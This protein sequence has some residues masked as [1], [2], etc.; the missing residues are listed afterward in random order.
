MLNP[1]LATNLHGNLWANG[2]SYENY[3]T[4][5]FFRT[6]QII[7]ILGYFTQNVDHMRDIIGGMA[8]YIPEFIWQSSQICALF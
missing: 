6:C 2:D 4:W 7:W 5:V 8:T 1:I 3:A